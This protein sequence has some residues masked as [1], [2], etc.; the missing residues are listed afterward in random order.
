MVRTIQY[1]SDSG[2]NE[3]DLGLE[4]FQG[5]FRSGMK[6]SSAREVTIELHEDV[7]P[8]AFK[9]AFDSLLHYVYRG[10]Q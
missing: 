4:Y 10:A 3:W 9:I 5:L 2:A 8:D 6:D 7:T 1:T